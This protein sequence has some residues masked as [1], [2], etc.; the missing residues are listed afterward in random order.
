M[1]DDQESNSVV[2]T[3]TENVEDAG[4]NQNPN[5]V[6]KRLKTLP[7]KTD[8]IAQLRS[9]QM[10][11]HHPKK[12]SASCWSVFGHPKVAGTDTFFPDSVFNANMGM[13]IIPRRATRN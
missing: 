6:N 7:S 11:I 2:A 12:K 3:G 1:E 13:C 10:V 4:G 5:T 9:G 8:V